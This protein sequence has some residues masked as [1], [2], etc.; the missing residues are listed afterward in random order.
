MDPI[1]PKGTIKLVSWEHGDGGW[2]EGSEE[3]LPAAPR[4][5]LGP[6][7][8]IPSENSLGLQEKQDSSLLPTARSE[9]PHLQPG[10]TSRRGTGGCVRRCS[11]SSHSGG[12][13]QLLQSLRSGKKVDFGSTLT[14]L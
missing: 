2:W 12:K 1:A 6:D 4:L 8:R 3:P 13:S 9:P 5:C 14:L 11:H 10:L 7:Q